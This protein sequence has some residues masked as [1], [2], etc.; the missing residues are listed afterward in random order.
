MKKGC[1]VVDNLFRESI[2]GEQ[3]GKDTDSSWYI[4]ASHKSCHLRLFGVCIYQDKVVLPFRSGKIIMDSLSR[5]GG[6]VHGQR[7]AAG[8]AFCVFVGTLQAFTG[9]LLKINI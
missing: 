7:G 5:A 9:N 3:V 6:H 4:S 8:G 2:S 1:T